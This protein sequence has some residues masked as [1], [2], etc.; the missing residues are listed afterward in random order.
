VQF[1]DIERV[2]WLNRVILQAWPFIGEYAKKY[3]KENI[4]PMVKA[5]L[6]GPFKSFRFEHMDMGDIPFRV[7][8]IKVR[9]AHAGT[10]RT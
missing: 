2:E 3:I 6:P 10:H 4:E 5:Q 1:P 9:A 7:G 8:G